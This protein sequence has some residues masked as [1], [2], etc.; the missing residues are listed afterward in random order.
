MPKQVTSTGGKTPQQSRPKKPYPEYPLS[1]HASG[2]WQK[3]V[4]GKIKYFG[5]WE[6][7]EAALAEYETFLSG[8]T[9]RPSGQDAEGDECS[10]D[11]MVN[12]FLRAKKNKMA[13]DDLAPRS[14]QQY[15][16]TCSLLKAHFGGERA[17]DSITPDELSDWRASWKNR[18]TGGA[19]S[20]SAINQR[21]RNLK[22]IFRFADD[23][24]LVDRPLKVRTVFEPVSVKAQLRYRDK[25]AAKYWERDEL[26]TLVA[27]ASPH[28]K[29]AMLLT[30]NAGFGATDFA[31]LR[32][33]QVDLKDGWYRQ[34]R[35]KTGIHRSAWL[36]PETRVAISAAMAMNVS[37]ADAKYDS[38]R[39]DLLP[40]CFWTK[41]RRRWVETNSNG[42]AQEFR[43]LRDDA[44]LRKK[45]VGIY[46]LRHNLQTLGEPVDSLAT[47]I[48]M[49]HADPSISATYREKFGQDRIKAVCEAVRDWFV[50]GKGDI[51]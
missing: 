42:V 22:T 19:L 6:N 4:D 16:D 48:V 39:D 43:K 40:L 27:A 35:G 7:P 14:Y 24:D 12:R 49:G 41:R 51:K 46:A 44:G 17:V 50:S 30:L 37:L 21:L 34:A 3:K 23:F 10:V 36:W 25:Q 26:L 9:L 32:R 15:R 33:D 13:E 18:K 38:V 11:Y 8:T 47:R 5:R 2:K 20:P 29:A 31:N 1:P 28:L 45:N